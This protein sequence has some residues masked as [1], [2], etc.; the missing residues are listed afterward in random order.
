MNYIFFPFNYEFSLFFGKGNAPSPLIVLE[1]ITLEG[2]TEL[3]I[4]SSAVEA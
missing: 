4:N 2:V 3:I 1:N